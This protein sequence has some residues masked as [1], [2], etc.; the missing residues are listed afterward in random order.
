MSWHADTQNSRC[1]PY[2]QCTGTPYRDEY[3][4]TIQLN[5]V[6]RSGGVMINC[7]EVQQSIET[8]Q[9]GNQGLQY[10]QMGSCWM[11]GG[12]LLKLK[13]ILLKLV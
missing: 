1:L 2:N 7:P 3:I 13:S 11:K 8:V 10:K 6:E 9:Y 12:L 4:L 5:S